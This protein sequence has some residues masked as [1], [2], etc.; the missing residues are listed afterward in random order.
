MEHAPGVQ[1]HGKWS[2]MNPHQ[3]ILCVKNVSF[4]VAEMA[5]LPFP[6]YGSLYFA[7]APIDLKSKIEF[8]E[9]FC[10]GPC[11]NTQYWDCNVTEPRFY[12][13]RLPNRGPCKWIHFCLLAQGD[14][15]E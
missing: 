4:A 13:E 2:S 12:E 3:H 10:I 15:Q 14:A 7:D 11:C 5:K 1:L 9:G 8:A 6:A